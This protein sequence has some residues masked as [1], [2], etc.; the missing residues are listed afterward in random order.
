[1]VRNAVFPAWQVLS[2]PKA[3]TTQYR[4][5]L[6]QRGVK[7]QEVWVNGEVEF[8]ISQ[9]HDPHVWKLDLQPD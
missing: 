4:A 5:E 3:W 7:Y 8:L 2:F 6:K 1:M 9:E